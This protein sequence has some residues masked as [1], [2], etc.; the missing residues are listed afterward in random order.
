VVTARHIVDPQWAKCG[1]PNPQIMYVRLNKLGGAQGI[2]FVPLPLVQNTK[3]LCMHPSDEKADAAVLVVQSP[4]TTLQAVNAEGIPISDFPTDDEMKA[5]GVG[6]QIA[7]AGL[8]PG[9]SGSNR[10]RAFFKFG[11]VSSISYEKIKRAA[12][13]NL[14]TVFAA[15]SLQQ[16][17][18]LET[19]A[20][21]SSSCRR[22]PGYII[23]L[24]CR[25]ARIARHSIVQSY[26]G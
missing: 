4:D 19:V 2:T 15:G 22:G 6:D 7:S 18:Y 9:F 5:I 3:S 14:L 10:N 1:I 24:Q 17:F 26:S 8:V 23:R 13:R 16:I 25:A 20:H 21:L 11:Y 12:R